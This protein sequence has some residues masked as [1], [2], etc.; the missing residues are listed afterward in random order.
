MCDLKHAC[1]CIVSTTWCIWVYIYIYTYVQT[2][3]NIYI[4][5]YRYTYTYLYIHTYVV[6]SHFAVKYTR[7]WWNSFAWTW[8]TRHVGSRRAI[9][10]GSGGFFVS[11][12]H[13]DRC[14]FLS[15]VLPPLVASTDSYWDRGK[16][17]LHHQPW[18]ATLVKWLE[19]QQGLLVWR[20]FIYYWHIGSSAAIGL[21]PFILVAEHP[22]Q[23]NRQQTGPRARGWAII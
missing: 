15:L 17:D 18:T 19:K 5:K 13:C 8:D 20:D 22:G 10:A 23:C 9:G 3:V 4:Y 21:L 1:V 6:F 16:S 14:C 7:N 11:L 2:Y 12:S